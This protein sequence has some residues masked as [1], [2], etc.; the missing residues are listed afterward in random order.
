MGCY[1]FAPL[2]ELAVVFAD[3]FLDDGDA[4]EEP[5]P[6]ANVFLVEVEGVGVLE[7]EEAL[8]LPSLDG[9][10]VV[11]GADVVG[12]EV[13][14]EAVVLVDDDDDEEEEEVEEVAVAVALLELL[15]LLLE[16]VP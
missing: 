13:V 9:G 15:L 14:A 5:L 8:A 3:A 6:L 12:V 7:E 10:D 2:E 16:S 4:A 11:F 1:R